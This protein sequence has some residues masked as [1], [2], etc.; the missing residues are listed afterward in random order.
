MEEKKLSEFI[1]LIDFVC[2]GMLQLPKTKENFNKLT[3]FYN[4]NK[5]L[6]IKYSNYRIVINGTEFEISN[7]PKEIPKNYNFKIILLAAF[8]D[9]NLI[10]I[11]DKIPWKLSS[12]M[13]RFKETT[14]NNHIVMG[15]KTFE[16]FKSPLKNRISHVITR[17]RDY[18]IDN[19][20]S[21]IVYVWTSIENCLA[22]LNTK[23]VE[24]V[25][26][27]GGGEIYKQTLPIADELQITRVLTTIKLDWVDENTTEKVIVFPFINANNWKITEN[28][29]NKKDEKNEYDYIFRT[30]IRE[31]IPK[32]IKLNNSL[33]KKLILSYS[34]ANL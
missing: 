9:N 34:I 26:I 2:S 22:Y 32:E 27:I 13:K 19:S 29:V 17:D 15:R 16:T 6:L 3:N 23:S 12:D 33:I 14:L 5:S 30:Y 11:G 20:F 24:N 21:E 8:D 4:K 10:G 31:E 18:V 28:I 25:Y 1:S 7:K